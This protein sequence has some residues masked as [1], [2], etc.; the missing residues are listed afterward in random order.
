MAQH[1]EHREQVA[2]LLEVQI[3]AMQHLIEAD[4]DRQEALVAERTMIFVSPDSEEFGRQRGEWDTAVRARTIAE[5]V[6]AVSDGA[7]S[8]REAAASADQAAAHL[9]RMAEALQRVVG[10]FRY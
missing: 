4:R 10:Q 1:E 2:A 7:D 5:N 8:T 9:A 6:T 3:P